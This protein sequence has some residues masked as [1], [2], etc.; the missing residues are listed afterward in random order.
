M[1]HGQKILVIGGGLIGLEIA[2]KLVDGDNL[3][4]IVEMMDETGRGMEMIEKAI[5]LKKLKAKN[6]KIFVNHKV[7]EISDSTVQL[8]GKDGITEID[9]IDKIVVATG[10]K[11]YIPFKITGKTPYY[12][13]GDAEE[14]GKAQ[15]AIHSAYRLAA[16]I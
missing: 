5:T 7:V 16:T 6:V 1:P 2:S 14:I 13:I 8:E 3:V 9:G 11:S 12:H 4:T 10:M 15:D